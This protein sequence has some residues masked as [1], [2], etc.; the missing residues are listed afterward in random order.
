MSKLYKDIL[1]GFKEI[2]E[3]IQ[4]EKIVKLADK[5]LLKANQNGNNVFKVSKNDNLLFEDTEDDDN[6]FWEEYYQE[7]KKNNGEK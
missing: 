3:I 5:Y 4:N 7:E 1:Q 6:E 2:V